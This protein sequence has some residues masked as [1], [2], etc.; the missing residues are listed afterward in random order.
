MVW[1]L[2]RVFAALVAAAFGASLGYLFGDAVGSHQP[3]WGFVGAFGGVALAVAYDLLRARPLLNWLRGPQT[4]DAPRNEGFWGELAYRIE[5]A[6]RSREQ[7]LAHERERLTQLL[8]AIDASPNGVILIDDD[9]RIEWCNATAAD[10]LGLEPARDLRQRV[11]NLVRAP[12]FVAHLQSGRTDQAVTFGLPGRPGSLAVWVRP[13]GAEGQKLLLTQDITERLR[14][15]E[16]RR[17]F[18]ANV[19][20][21][22]RTP[23]TVLSGFVDTMNQIELAAGERRRVLALMKEQTDRMRAL[24]DDLLVLAQLDS[25]PRPPVDRW[26]NVQALMQR[27]QADAHTLSGGKHTLQ[28]EGGAGCAIAGAESELFGAMLNLVVNAVRYTPAAGTIR[29][30][31]Q[32]RTQGGGV[33]EVRDTGIG[34][35]R[36]HLARLGERFYRID[37]GRSR[38][39]GGTGL[40][41]AIAKHAV[42]RHGGELQVDSEP[43]RGSSFRLVFP[44]AR[45]QQRAAEAAEPVSAET[46]R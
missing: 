5:R 34:I 35:P 9:E 38:G 24:L 21:E 4:Q 46:R 22:I 32:R 44:A 15:D 16:M 7:D 43:G 25:G 28:F 12:A 2:P 10:H 41:L 8:S 13:Y 33:F 23:L 37:D 26:V 17:D 29:V 19:S 6:L 11:T 14:T 40:G 1:L 20:H 31:W 42:Q 39:T 18:V 30:L 3:W 36:E 45:V 27:L